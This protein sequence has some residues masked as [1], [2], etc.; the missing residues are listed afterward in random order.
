MFLSFSL[1]LSIS[2]SASPVPILPGLPL[3]RRSFADRTLLYS[4]PGAV[5]VAPP[6]SNRMGHALLTYRSLFNN[7]ISYHDNLS[8]YSTVFPPVRALSCICCLYTRFPVPSQ[9]LRLPELTGSRF[10]SRPLHRKNYSYQ[11]FPN[12]HYM[13]KLNYLYVCVYNLLIRIG[14]G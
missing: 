6:D 10:T 13:G 9:S 2:I 1:S 14:L 4:P 12:G 8:D 3:K 5:R 11:L 7:L